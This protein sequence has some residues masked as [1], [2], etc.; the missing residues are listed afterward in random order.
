MKSKK[1]NKSDTE[2]IDLGNKKLYKYPSP[3]NK[4]EVKKAYI[5]G[6]SPE[7]P[8]RAFIECE[9]FAI[10][11]LAG[12]GKITL[13]D[14]MYSLEPEDVIYVVENTKF[15]IEGENLEYVLF[16]APVWIPEQ[17]KEVEL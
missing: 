10:Y 7:N 12:K 2:L 5:N 3:T 8:Q 9:A 6:R 11:V 4:F 16:N 14:S 17:M 13:D 1:L 15:S